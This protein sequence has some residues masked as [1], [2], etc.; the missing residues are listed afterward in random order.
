MTGMSSSILNYAAEQRVFRVGDRGEEMFVVLS[1]RVEIR[2]ATG[3]PLTQLGVGESFGEIAIVDIG[4]RSADAWA[5]EDGTRLLPIDRARF[6]YLVSQQ[7]AFALA[8]MA[9]MSRRLRA[10]TGTIEAHAAIGQLATPRTEW[11]VIEII[12]GLFQ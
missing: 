12:E 10:K 5:I 3:Y 4:S 2:S 11:E 8:V 6:V 7:P 9:S 1:G